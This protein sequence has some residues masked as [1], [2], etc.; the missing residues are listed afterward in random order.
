[1]FIQRYLMQ[2][3]LVQFL[4]KNPMAFFTEIEKKIQNLYGI[5]KDLR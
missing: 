3:E 5:P 4:L 2:V 1:M